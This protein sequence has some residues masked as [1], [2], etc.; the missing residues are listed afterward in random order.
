MHRTANLLLMLAALASAFVLY[1]LKYDARQ[2]EL[3]VQ[4]QERALE[5]AEADLAVLKAERALL[6]RPDRLEPLARSLGL[7]PINRR[8]YVRLDSGDAGAA[9]A[10]DGQATAAG[11]GR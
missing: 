4:A 7:V 9:K 2:L 5:K 8:Q 3:K 6:A 1:T 11:E 10:A